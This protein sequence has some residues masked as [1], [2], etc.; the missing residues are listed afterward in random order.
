MGELT[1]EEEDFSLSRN[2]INK[3]IMRQW[4]S[5]HNSLNKIK[6][7]ESYYIEPRNS[8]AEKVKPNSVVNRY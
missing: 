8:E 3:G 5:L 6:S 7:I 2:S 4:A 1:E